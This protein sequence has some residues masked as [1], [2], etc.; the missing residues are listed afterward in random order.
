MFSEN[1]SIVV[2]DVYP[3]SDTAYPS[4]KPEYPGIVHQVKK[5]IYTPHTHPV[6]HFNGIIY[7]GTGYYV[8]IPP[9]SN[10]PPNGGGGSDPKVD[11][12]MYESYPP[13][14]SPA[15]LPQQ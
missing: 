5:G 2:A 12:N 10:V 9:Q 3:S 8:I 1:V 4:P 14:S 6:P 11:P 7:V 13:C 15:P